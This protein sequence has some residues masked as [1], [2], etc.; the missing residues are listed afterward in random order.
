MQAS[1]NCPFDW[2]LGD[3]LF[4]VFLKFI[5]HLKPLLLLLLLLLF[6]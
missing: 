2:A 3:V 6:E 4:G 1:S 5:F